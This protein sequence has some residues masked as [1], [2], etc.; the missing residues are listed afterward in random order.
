MSFNSDINCKF[1]NSTAPMAA[2]PLFFQP[3]SRLPFSVLHMVGALVVAVS[4]MSGPLKAGPLPARDVGLEVAPVWGDSSL[5]LTAEVGSDASG[6]T[7]TVS[8]L[9]FILS[10]VA[11]RREDGSWLESKDW[12]AAY[13]CD[14]GR[15]T[16]LIQGVPSQK[17]T[18]LRFNVG[19]DPL[20]NASDPNKRAL[21]HPL[22]PLVNG[23]RWG[24]QAG[25]VFL[26]LEG[27]YQ[28]RDGSFGG[29]SCH[30]ANNANLMR[31]EVPISLEAAGARTIRLALDVEKLFHGKNAISIA[32][33]GGFTHW[34]GG[35][36]LA[37]AVKQNVESAFRVKNITSDRYQNLA[38]ADAAPTT[39]LAVAPGG[40]LFR[41]TRASM[42][43]DRVEFTN[44]ASSLTA[45]TLIPAS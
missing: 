6:A 33:S 5:L 32:K 28:K 14:Q 29:Y 16:A 15:R 37:A 42:R 3:N 25:Y 19:V 7:V 4:S 18:A 24:R 10:A 21:D 12:F 43:P 45:V 34:G 31:V 22:H 26:A 41:D 35:D 30:I 23:L 13:R 40:R 44:A 2:S 8:R 38:G 36:T 20:T 27:R 17:F 11:L 1:D 39:F 9:D